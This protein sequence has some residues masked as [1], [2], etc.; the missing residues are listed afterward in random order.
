MCLYLTLYM[1]F[2]KGYAWAGNFVAAGISGLVPELL[3]IT[4]VSHMPE[5]VLLATADDL[6]RGQPSVI[7]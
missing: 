6:G 5:C 3:H 1:A 4:Q 7:I 2:G